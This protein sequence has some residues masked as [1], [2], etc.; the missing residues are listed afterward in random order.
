MCELYMV[1][2]MMVVLR[3]RSVVKSF[4]RPLV[5]SWAFFGL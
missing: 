4:I 2:V 1:F 3:G 5:T